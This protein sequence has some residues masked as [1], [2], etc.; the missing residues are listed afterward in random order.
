[1]KP[2]S[3]QYLYSAWSDEG[4]SDM[5]NITVFFIFF[6]FEVYTK[7]VNVLQ[8][9]WLQTW[10]LFSV[11]YTTIGIYTLSNSTNPRVTYYRCLS[12]INFQHNNC[13]PINN[14]SVKYTFNGVCII[15]SGFVLTRLFDRITLPE[16][17]IIVALVFSIMATTFLYLHI[18]GQVSHKSGAL[19][20][21][22]AT[23][24]DLSLSPGDKKLRNREVKSIRPFGIRV[25][26]IR[27]MSYN[28][29]NDYF[30]QLSSVFLTLLVTFPV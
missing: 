24:V 12:L 19:C 23:H 11:A 7:I 30:V 25:G 4:K 17:V 26:N 13:Y 20:V 10:F 14:S 6:T 8:Y 2:G 16:Q 3:A 9:F 29:L 5:A 21:K 18:S 28:A 15:S 1:M 22:L 27:S